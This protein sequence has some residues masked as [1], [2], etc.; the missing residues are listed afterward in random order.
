MPHF[1]F[2][3]L[4]EKDLPELHSTFVEAFA[5]YLVPIQLD[6]AQFQAKLKREGVTP[7]FCVA[8]YEGKQMAGFI[9]T[10]LGEW[11]GK[12]TAYN[13][14]TGVKPQ[15]RGNRLTEQLYGF[16][17]PKLLESGVEQ[18]LLEV[19]QEN[20]PALKAYKAIGFQTSRAL[21]C[22]RAMKTELLLQ[23]KAPENVTIGVTQNPDW[24]NYHHFWDMEPT[25]QNSTE[26]LKQSPD[27]KAVLEARDQEA[28]LLGYL[29]LFL[30]SGAVAQFAVDKKE[31]GRGIGTALLR[32]AVNLAEA[33]ALMF[34]NVD[35]TASGF[36]YYLERRHFKR[37]L[38]QYEM[39]M[40]LA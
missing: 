4:T 10:G 32:E 17:F 13:A 14:G 21:D 29:V 15:F 1:Q 35:T 3:F 8:A 22:F 25:W 9:L 26:A 27:A 30:K 20:A 11:E 6:Y 16:L 33:P 31:R 18:C 19:I 12:P 38:G 40:P 7:S 23:V 34:I 37:M 36:I 28:E 39:K 2:A 5:D 24:K